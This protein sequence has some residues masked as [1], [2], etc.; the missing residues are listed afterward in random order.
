MPELAEVEIT[1]RA[2]LPLIRGRRILNFW[3][4]WPRGLKLA[5]PA[6]VRRDIVGRKI[7]A[8]QRRG[9]VLFFKLSGRP[10]RMLAVH[11][12]MSGRLEVVTD[13]FPRSPK[14]FVVQ[15]PRSWKLYNKTSRRKEVRWVH[16]SWRLSGSRELRL[17]DPRK[18]GIVWY[19]APREL[20]R[21]S[22]LG[23]LGRDAHGLG[24]LEFAAA[25]AASRGMTKPFLLRQDRLAGIG[26]IIADEALWRAG[27]HP[28]TRVTDLNARSRQRLFY[29]IQRTIR[30]MLSSGG[31]TLRNWGSPDGSA[32]RYQERRLVYGK[33]GLPCPRC[34][35]TLR[36]IVVGGRG[37]TVCPACQRH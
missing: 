20:G 35:A 13:K 1:R 31:T 18:F 29:G 5:R 6:V 28:E 14:N 2:L 7:L 8:I 36:R 27:V 34:R 37:T 33:A 22:Y 19:G 16:F 30:A 10:E 12:R 26:N 25:L 21:D 17:V 32:G 23:K 3:T 15:F 4:D 24:Y 9:K 11:F